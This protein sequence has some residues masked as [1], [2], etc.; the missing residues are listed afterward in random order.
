MTDDIKLEDARVSLD[1]SF[2]KQDQDNPELTWPEDMRHIRII[3]CPD[4]R[5]CEVKYE[6]GVFYFRER[7][8]EDGHF[9]MISMDTLFRRVF[10][11]LIKANDGMD[12]AAALEH[13]LKALPG[14]EY[15]TVAEEV[16]L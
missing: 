9:A 15:L 1:V 14:Y 7:D 5:Q 13:G 16:T 12:P 10:V 8:K 2:G 6:F 4:M 3:G 11:S